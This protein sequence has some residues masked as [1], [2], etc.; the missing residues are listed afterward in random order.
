M[1]AQQRRDYLNR[2][3]LVERS[4]TESAMQE[5]KW[6][7]LQANAQPELDE[8]GRPVFNVRLGDETVKVG[9]TSENIV[10]STE[11]TEIAQHFLLVRL[12]EELRRNGPKAAQSDV[13]RDLN[14][15]E[16]L[17]RTRAEMSSPVAGTY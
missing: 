4:I 6:P 12:R 7:R 17:K 2:V 9:L 3:E 13:H 5:V 1:T 14:L 15:L 10:S 16:E 11:S 8:A